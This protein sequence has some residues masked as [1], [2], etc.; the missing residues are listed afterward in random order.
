[1]SRRLLPV[2]LAVG[3]TFP[4]S[5]GAAGSGP[6]PNVVIFATDDLRFDAIGAY[7]HPFSQTPNLDRLASEGAR[8]DR[9]YATTPLCSPWRASFLTGQYMSANGWTGNDQHAARAPNLDDA[10]MWHEVLNGAGYRTGYVGKYHLDS[11]MGDGNP[12]NR[13]GTPRPGWDYWAGFTS[14]QGTHRDIQLNVNGAIVNTTGYTSDT[15]A[16][17]A[18]TFLAGGGNDEPFALV[19]SYKAVHA[20]TNDPNDVSPANRGLYSE[21]QVQAHLDTFAA[22]NYPEATLDANKPVLTRAGGPSGGNPVPGVTGT[23]NTAIVGQLRQ[24]KDVDD[25]VGRVIAQLESQGLL[26]NTIIMFTSDSGLGWREHGLGGKSQAYEF[27]ARTPLI[28]RHPTLAA[29]GQAPTQF[30][31]NVDIGPTLLAAA[32][33]EVPASMQGRSMLPYLNGSGDA[34]REVLYLE[35]NY[36]GHAPQTNSWQ[37]VIDGRYKYIRYNDYKNVDE[38][39]DMRADPHEIYNV[40]SSP[41]HAAAIKRLK[42]ELQL[43][44]GA[45]LSPGEHRP[46]YAV[47]SS[48]NDFTLAENATAINNTGSGANNRVGANGS[49]RGGGRNVVFMVELPTLGAG[50]RVGGADFRFLLNSSAGTMPAGLGGDLWSLGIFDGDAQSAVLGSY[51]EAENDPVAGRVKIQDDLLAPAMAGDQ[52]IRTDGSASQVMAGLLNAFYDGRPDYAGGAYLYLRLNPDMDLGLGTVG[53]D[54]AP[55][56]NIAHSGDPLL[57]I[58]VVPEPGSL[59]MLVAATGCLCL[60]GR[61]RRSGEPVCDA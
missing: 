56:E 24:L 31:T 27:S 5:A 36:D 58:T 53:W 4:L 42:R 41:A 35:H 8:F 54:V 29:G 55:V 47:P 46:V 21:A 22:N 44:H 12:D 23:G 11:W 34:G 16:T 43:G 6:R 2:V 9:S 13:N 45:A 10:T 7:G 25:S 28:V 51:I 1:M 14:N 38:L 32:G 18:N 20:P 50:E 19:V 40:I 60:A 48:F 39:Y 26:E 33:V 15:L 49:T 57:V 37:S 3:A 30:V 59:T 61:R 17:Y 52:I